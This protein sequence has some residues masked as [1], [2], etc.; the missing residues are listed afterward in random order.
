MVGHEAIT[1]L[2]LISL[3]GAIFL[4]GFSEAIGV[5]VG[6]VAV[7]LLLNVVVIGRAWLEILQDPA[8]L[9]TGVPRS[10]CS[11]AAWSPWC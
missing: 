3:L 11:T 10:R 5:A 9:Q 2:L 4:R 7:Y 6:I 8:L 1:T